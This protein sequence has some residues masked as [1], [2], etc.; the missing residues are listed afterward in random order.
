MTISPIW[1]EVTSDSASVS[2][3]RWMPLTMRSTR[4]SS[5]GRLRSAMRM[6]RESF[7]RSKGTRRPSLL[8][9]VS[10]R[11][12]TRSKV[13]KRLWQPGQERRRRMAAPSSAGRLSFTCVSSRP[14]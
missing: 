13:V 2:S 9:T 3:R 4:S 12:C 14:Q 10:S 5:T 11:S 6:E 1:R 7:S 8:S